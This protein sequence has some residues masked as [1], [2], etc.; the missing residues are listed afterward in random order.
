M[1]V[2]IK[3]LKD[4]WALIPV[5]TQLTYLMMKTDAYFR[6]AVDCQ[7]KPDGGSNCSCN[8]RCGF[9]FEL[10]NMSPG[11]CHATIN[12]TDAFFA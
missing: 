6:I 4:A 11:T 5:C 8:A 1:S 7:P 9:T 3:V 2:A 10:I 12:L